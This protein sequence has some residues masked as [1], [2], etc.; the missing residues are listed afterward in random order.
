MQRTVT[1]PA[2]LSGEALDDL[3]SWLGISRAREDGL[4]MDLLGASLALCEAYI[5][6]APLEQTVEES[7]P[8]S[9]RATELSSS[10][11]IALLAAEAMDENGNRSILGPE[12]YSFRIGAPQ[13]ASIEILQPINAEA[14]VVTIRTG[15]ASEWGSVP[16]ALK[17]GII[18]LAAFHYRDREP[19]RSSTPPASVAALWRP[20]RAM[21]IA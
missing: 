18:R 5:G 20:W 3:K 16:H 8:A 2:D 7:I 14:I 1:T 13:N 21:R 15:I 9:A 4:L 12:D 11:V 19:G 17:Q 6:K 10:P